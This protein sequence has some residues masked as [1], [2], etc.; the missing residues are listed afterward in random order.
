MCIGAGNVTEVPLNTKRFDIANNE[1][2]DAP[3]LIHGHGI[4]KTIRKLTN[5]NPQL[6]NMYTTELCYLNLIPK[7]TG[8]PNILL[9]STHVFL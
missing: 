1:G 4:L 2:S 5:I 3:P 6:P 7:P 9:I 8:L